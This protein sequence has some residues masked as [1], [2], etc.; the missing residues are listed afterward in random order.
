MIIESAQRYN[1]P[2]VEQAVELDDYEVRNFSNEFI[3]DVLADYV[4]YENKI[5]VIDGPQLE[6]GGLCIQEH[7]NIVANLAES[8][9]SL[10][11]GMLQQL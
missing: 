9:A 1:Q 7:G 6:T 10:D 2:S 4:P 3:A 5:V 11:G 8:Q